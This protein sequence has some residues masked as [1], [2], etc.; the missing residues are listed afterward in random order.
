V[1]LIDNK[2]ALIENFGDYR[3]ADCVVKN[4]SRFFFLA[5][6]VYHD[7][8]GAEL[9]EQPDDGDKRIIRVEVGGDEL[10]FA[11]ANL[12]GYD[13]PVYCEM[14]YPQDKIVVVDLSGRVYFG[15]IRSQPMIPG[16]TDGGLLQGAV[17]RVRSIGESAAILISTGRDALIHESGEKWNR[18]GQPF[19]QDFPAYE[20]FKDFDG[21]STEEIYAVG[22]SGGV[23][24]Y[25]GKRWAQMEFPTNKGVSSVCCGGDENVYVGSA[26]GKIYRGKDHEW[27]LI[28]DDDLALPYRDMVWH[29]DC[30]WCG[31]D[32]GLWK[33]KDGKPVDDVPS[34]ASVCCGHLSTRGGVLL[35]AGFGGAAW[36]D[37]DGKW[38]VLFLSVALRDDNGKADE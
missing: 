15:D 20:G 22:G 8:Q 31:N 34:K 14:T 32:S 7:D 9:P 13:W 17:T 35:T 33:F 18:L 10:D 23:F 36:L 30:L 27:E 6:K 11:K 38:N 1:E 2:E 21:F 24:K 29:D 16:P 5:S 4:K 12:T 26:G 25:D 28:H 19:A 3:I 37:A